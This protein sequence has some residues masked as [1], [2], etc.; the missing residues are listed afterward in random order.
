MAQTYQPGVTPHQTR[1]EGEEPKSSGFYQ[2][3]GPVEGGWGFVFLVGRSY[4]DRPAR[5]AL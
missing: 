2:K 5:N 1:N 3:G 4:R